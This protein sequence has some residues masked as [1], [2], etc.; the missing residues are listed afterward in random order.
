MAND[1]EAQLD[2]VSSYKKYTSEVNHEI[3][4]AEKRIAQKML[5]EVK[6]TS[7]VRKLYKNKTNRGAWYAEYVKKR[8]GSYKRGWKL[9]T[10]TDESGD[11]MTLI[12]YNKTDAPLAHLV[13]L[14]HLAGS[15]GH[16]VKG[17]GHIRKAQKKAREEL[18]SEI[19]NILR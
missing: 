10:K 7:P 19:K 9:R 15:E 1:N 14:G 11:V 16:E 17:T 3:R 6:K 8:R 12:V 18:N 4:A 5:K 2:L 13:D